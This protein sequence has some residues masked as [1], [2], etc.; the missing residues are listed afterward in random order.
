MYHAKLL[1]LHVGFCYL[2]RT[3]RNEMCVCVCMYVPTHFAVHGGG[4]GGGG[5][6]NET[7]TFEIREDTRVAS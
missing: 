1:S 2:L 6:R 7:L 4:R 5:G 3:A